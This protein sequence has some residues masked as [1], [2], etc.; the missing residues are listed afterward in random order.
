METGIFNGSLCGQRTRLGISGCF[1]LTD[2][3][4]ESISSDSG[5]DSTESQSALLIL[6]KLFFIIYSLTLICFS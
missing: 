4:L 5:G 6:E 3:I 1:S 2:F